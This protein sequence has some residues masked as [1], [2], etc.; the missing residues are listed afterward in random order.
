MDHK[1]FLSSLSPEQRATL[2]RRRNFPA[3]WH[4]SLHW[5]LI[6]IFGCYIGFKLPY[7]GIMLIPQGIFLAF[8]FN[9]LHE[10]V[11]ETPFNSNWLNTF[12]GCICSCLVILPRNWF[13]YFHLAHHKYTHQT[14]KDPELIAPKPETIG[15]YLRYASGLPTLF[16]NV[17][18]IINNAFVENNDPYVPA[19]GKANIRKEALWMLGWYALLICACFLLGQRWIFWCWFLPFLLGQPFLRLYLL[20]EHGRCPMVADMFENTR[21]T[22]TNRIVRF[23]AWNMPYH[24]EHHVYPSVPFHQLPMLHVL[25]AENLKNTSDGYIEFHQEYLD[26]LGPV[27]KAD[28]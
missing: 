20:A 15:Q 21:T 6:I 1:A 2:T 14:G 27:P 19:R 10:T 4:L 3:L 9:L 13:R 12:T 23:L 17:K 11:H 18:K 28:F 24:I 22:F 5:G 8:C 16:G 26:T 25:V 7:W